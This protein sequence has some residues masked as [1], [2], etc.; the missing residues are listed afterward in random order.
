MVRDMTPNQRLAAMIL[1]EPVGNWITLQ[2][3]QGQS[4]RAIADDLR[5]RTNGQVNVSHE[6]IRRWTEEDAA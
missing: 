3:T 1:G 4:W 2:R 5:V 6:A